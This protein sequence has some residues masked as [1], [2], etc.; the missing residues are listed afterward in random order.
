MRTCSIVALFMLASVPAAASPIVVSFNHLLD[1]TNPNSPNGPLHGLRLSGAFA[2]DEPCPEG[3]YAGHP[4][5]VCDWTIS[6]GYAPMLSFTMNIGPYHFDLSHT[7][8]AFVQTPSGG[9]SWGPIANIAPAFLPNDIAQLGLFAD[10]LVGFL[11][12]TDAG[13]YYVYDLIETHSS[14]T[15]VPAPQT[16]VVLLGSL[17]GF[18]LMKRAR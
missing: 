12:L 14:P 9:N 2:Y 6:S 10:A 17:V 4:N 3:G 11:Y 13:H 5:P 7:V 8:D 15:T 1:N 16:W 18:A